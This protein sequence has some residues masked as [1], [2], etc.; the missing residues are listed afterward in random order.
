MRLV[1]KCFLELRTGLLVL[2]IEPALVPKRLEI[3][4]TLAW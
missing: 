2:P 4:T 3:E 1:F